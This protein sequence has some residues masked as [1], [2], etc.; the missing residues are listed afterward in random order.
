MTKKIGIVVNNCFKTPHETEEIN[1]KILREELLKLGQK[2][3]LFYFKGDGSNGGI[4]FS[5]FKNSDIDEVY[6]SG[7]ISNKN[8]SLLVF[9]SFFKRIK[10]HFRIPSYNLSSFKKYGFLFKL[11]SKFGI[12]ELYSYDSFHKNF[13][14][15]NLGLKTRILEPI[16]NLSE[17]SKNLKKD[18]DVLFVGSLND[19][20]RGLSELLEAL[21]IVKKT[22]PGVRLKIISRYE[23][24]TKKKD[25]FAGFRG[26]RTD[27]VK[28]IKSLVEQLGLEKNVIFSGKVE[29]VSKE[30]DKAKLYVL[31]VRDFDKMPPIPFT[32]LESLYHKT[33]VIS[34]DFW[35][36]S[37]IL[38]KKFLV[39]N[40]LN[41]SEFS[42]DLAKKILWV[43][44]NNPTVSL[45]KRYYPSESAR[46]FLS[47]VDEKI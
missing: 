15:E 10:I 39:E 28:T 37:S 36:V 9:Y 21:M 42:K 30:Y 32:I 19:L 24:Y 5:N 46:K 8:F 33:P 20:K 14:K 11:L 26:K 1:A 27:I 16:I 18:V 3:E 41:D 23:V 29:S 4:P 45:E 17:L 31:P 2:V 38:E 7:K 22:H 25:W 43:L 12:L 34:S 13:I 40:D 47:Y 44:K 6:L 35:G